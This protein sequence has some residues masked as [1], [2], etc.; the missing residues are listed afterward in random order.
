MVHLILIECRKGLETLDK[1]W[2]GGAE[3]VDIVLCVLG[4]QILL[5]KC[6]VDNKWNRK[7]YEQKILRAGSKRDYG[8]Q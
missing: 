3:F 8:Q 1:S 5:L 4:S 6:C 2:V 7:W